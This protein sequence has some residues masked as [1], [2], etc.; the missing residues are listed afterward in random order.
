[1]PAAAPAVVKQ[2]ADIQILIENRTPQGIYLLI[3]VTENPRLEKI[4]II[5]NDEL[6]E[7]E[8]GKKIN[9]VKTAA[10]TPAVK[11]D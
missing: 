11:V 3:R 2:S 8:V 5:G 7:D 9:L 6:S 4:E 10:S 1:M